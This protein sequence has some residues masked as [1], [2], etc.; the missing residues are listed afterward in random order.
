MSREKSIIISSW[1]G[2]ILILLFLTPK[3]K[4][5]QACVI[6]L[7]Q[8]TYTWIAG[9]IA[10]E[11]GLI[12]YPKRLFFKKSYKGSF[13]FE[14]LVFPAITVLFNMYY[15]KNR[16]PIVQALYYIFYCAI[17]TSLETIAVK[18]T[19]LITYKNWHWYWSFT[20]MGFSFYI[21]RSFY[22][23]FYKN[24]LA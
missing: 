6:F 5:R 11:K 20:T 18:F 1:V 19:R 7:F 13:T 24:E 15:P 2:S 23:W 16:V 10:V 12:S 9:L 4:I 17:I 3:S 21:S 14:H 22:K 8:Q